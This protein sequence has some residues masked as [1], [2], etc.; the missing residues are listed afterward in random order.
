MWGVFHAVAPIR[1][2]KRPWLRGSIWSD[3]G[4][5][6]VSF[7]IRPSFLEQ[8][9]SN[10]ILGPEPCKRSDCLFKGPLS[11]G[12][13]AGFGIPLLAGIHLP[14]L[15][16]AFKAVVRTPRYFARIVTEAMWFSHSS[17][18]LPVLP[19]AVSVYFSFSMGADG[20]SIFMSTRPKSMLAS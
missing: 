20:F 11:I 17:W 1:N 15:T 6:A 5:D 14:E 9:S 16:F 2:G 7:L 13:E 10:T 12:I 4:R 3:S 8:T 19:L 18:S